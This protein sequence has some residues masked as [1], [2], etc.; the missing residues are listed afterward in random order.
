MKKTVGIGIAVA[1]V[2]TVAGGLYWTLS[3]TSRETD[4]PSSA[5]AAGAA[6]AAVM[7]SGHQA[8]ASFTTGTESLPNSLQGTEVDGELEVDAGGHL[9]ITNGVRHVFDYF[10]SATGEEPLESILARIHAYIRHKLPPVAAAEAEQILDGYIAYKRGL[11]NI[12]QAQNSAN[13]SIDIDAVR[14]QMQQ[15]QALRTQYLSPA[16][17]TAFFG[18]ED[19]YDRYTLA[20][21]E[22]M[23]NKSISAAQRAQQL[24]ALEQ[25]LPASIQESMKTINQYQNL[26]ALQ[27]DWKKRGG[28]PA[29]LRQI[30]ENLV[31]AE[32]TNRLES[33]DA[34]RAGW[35][36]RMSSW[37]DERAA[38]LGNKNL[39]DD[40]RQRQL[41]TLRKSRFSDSERLRVESLEHM[42]DRGETVGQ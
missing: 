39:S 31:G 22:L 30:R 21:I 4:A 32:A 26:E 27:A 17:I 29:E 7:A 11:E 25:Q 16:V 6:G 24:A 20:R 33:L 13:G 28:S 9:K 40:D 35:D 14:R 42:R 41:D 18:D 36:Q 5:S 15:V 34:E 23:Q 19:A 1:L 2:L 10:L 37:Y 38:I 12:Q 3:G 8:P